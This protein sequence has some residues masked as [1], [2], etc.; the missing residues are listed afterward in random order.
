MVNERSCSVH[1]RAELYRSRHN[2]SIRTLD[3]IRKYNC[4]INCLFTLIYTRYFSARRHLAAGSLISD[5]RRRSCRGV[6][7]DLLC[8]RKAHDSSSGGYWKFPAAPSRPANRS[9][10]VHRELPEELALTSFILQA[11]TPVEHAI[12]DGRLILHPYLFHPRGPNQSPS[13][14]INSSGSPSL[15]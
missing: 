15:N 3:T 10:C 14:A 1:R 11:L 5:R 6:T 4:S 12:P 8:Q 7:H 13:Q 9:D 2:V